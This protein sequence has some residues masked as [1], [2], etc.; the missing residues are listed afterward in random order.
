MSTLQERLA[1][2]MRACQWTHADLVRI[3]G[4]SSSVVS[5]WRGKSSKI[6]KSIGS[7]DAAQRI[8]AASGY[9]ALWVATGQG[10]KLKAQESAAPYRLSR[11]PHSW[12]AR[13]D[14][15]SPEQRDTLLGIVEDLL[16][17][18]EAANTAARR[19]PQAAG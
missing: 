12:H 1:E 11:V 4:Q 10:P 5:Q 16:V 9:A 15:L 8:E 2:V 14:A 18:Y 7:L 3:S 17:R 13:F 19:K 6:I